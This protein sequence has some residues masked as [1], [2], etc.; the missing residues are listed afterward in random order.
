MVTYGLHAIDD[1]LY[2]IN[3]LRKLSS[4]KALTLRICP[5]LTSL[6]IIYFSYYL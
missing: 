3:G 1:F 6:N 4:A 5:P 2:A